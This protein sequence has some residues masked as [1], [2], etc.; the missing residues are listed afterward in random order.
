MRDGCA[1][2]RRH[3]AKNDLS[4]TLDN[5]MDMGQRQ[6]GSAGRSARGVRCDA[7]YAAWRCSSGTVAATF[8]RMERRPA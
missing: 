5:G 2:D 4:A 6:G 1:F 3:R 7:S 8:R